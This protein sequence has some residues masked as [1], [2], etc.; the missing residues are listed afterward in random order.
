MLKGTEW[1]PTAFTVCLYADLLF[2]PMLYT[3]LLV[4][5][6]YVANAYSWLPIG[7]LFCL[8]QLAL[9]GESPHLAEALADGRRP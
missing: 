2:L 5:Q 3:N 6:N 4:C 7:I 8:P 1:F 9:D